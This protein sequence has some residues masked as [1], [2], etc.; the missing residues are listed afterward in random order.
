VA[1]LQEPAAWHA[2]VAGGHVTGLDP[3]HIPATHEYVWSH[4]FDPT[5]GVPHAPQLP[6]SV[7]VFTHAEPQRLG[8][9]ALGHVA[10]QLPL[11]HVSVPLV[12]RA[13]QVTH[14]MPQ[15][16]WP[17]LQGLQTPPVQLDPVGHAC[18]HVPQL[19]WSTDVSTSQPLAGLW[20]Q[21]AIGA[22]Q[23]GLLHTPFTQVSVPPFMLQCAPQA[24]QL[25]GSAPV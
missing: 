9:E 25:A 20:S 17:A 7:C 10:T 22:V 13:G 4:L 23:T 3:V 8:N 15:S 1:G 11:P 2:S 5:Q 18:P 19:P 12:G 6:L 24:P 14:A 16:S 21:S